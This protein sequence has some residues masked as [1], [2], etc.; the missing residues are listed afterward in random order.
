MA[1]VDPPKVVPRDTGAVP[2]GKPLIGFAG[3]ET[4]SVAGKPS[5]A[6]LG[7]ARA[8]AGL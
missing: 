1:G 6:V 2:R 3:R 5:I 4:V 7:E 8:S